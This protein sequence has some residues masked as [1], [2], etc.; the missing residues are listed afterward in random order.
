[1]R[2]IFC[3]VAGLLVAT[4]AQ[5]LRQPFFDLFA[6]HMQRITFGLQK[7]TF[8]GE[9]QHYDTLYRGPSWYPSLTAAAY[10]PVVKMFAVGLGLGLAM[11]Q[12]SGVAALQRQG[13]IER[14]PEEK[15][16]LTLLPARVLF[17]AA[18][19]PLGKWISIDFGIGLEHLYGQEVRVSSG[20][21][22]AEAEANGDQAPLL[23]K[24]WQPYRV[25]NGGLS[26]SLHALE[27]RAMRALQRGFAI[28][29]V[30]LSLAAE[31]VQIM[32]RRGTDFSRRSF[33]L[34]V[35]FEA[36]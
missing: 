11:Y 14:D 30:Y 1:M 12:D 5:A 17:V 20:A 2:L 16:Q 21:A 8:T 34:A 27:K 15:T 26:L 29:N 9:L 18:L 25:L 22:D 13:T 19:R 4:P 36:D 10:L 23:N 32:R 31:Q 7:P 33:I 3:L 28:S 6:Q 35:T 24:G